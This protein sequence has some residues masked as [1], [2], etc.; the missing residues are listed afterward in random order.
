MYCNIAAPPGCPSPSPSV[1]V[2]TVQNDW[3]FHVSSVPVY[4]HRARKYC[5]NLGMDLAP[6]G[7]DNDYNAL[8]EFLGIYEYDTPFCSVWQKLLSIRVQYHIM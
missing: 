8:E 7:S 6:I 1:P 2:T 3:H 4:H 5:M